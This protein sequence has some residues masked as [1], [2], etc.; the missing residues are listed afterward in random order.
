MTRELREGVAVVE[1]RPTSLEV[2]VLLV[3]EEHLQTL[4]RVLLGAMYS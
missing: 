3:K 4:E 1:V 2:D